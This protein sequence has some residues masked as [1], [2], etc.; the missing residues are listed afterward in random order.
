MAEPAKNQ[1]AV[2]ETWGLPPGPEN[3]LAKGMA[4]LQEFLPGESWRS[5]AGYNPWDRKESNT[6]EQLTP[7]PR[8]ARPK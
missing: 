2:Q 4:I 3:P 5:P 6:T 8:N 1:T 7:I